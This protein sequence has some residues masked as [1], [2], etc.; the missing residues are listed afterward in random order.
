VKVTKMAIRISD[1]EPE[2]P[3]VFDRIFMDKLTCEQVRTASLTAHPQYVISI[4]YRLRAIDSKN[5]FTYK[6]RSNSI[7]IEDFYMM[8]MEQAQTGEMGLVNA[9]GAI[10]IAVAKI[11][12]D[13]SGIEV[14]V[15]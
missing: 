2:E 3:L 1:V 8:A 7:A 9:L 14:K 10:Q 6:K 11:I 4:E 15:I 12:S 5:Q 13:D